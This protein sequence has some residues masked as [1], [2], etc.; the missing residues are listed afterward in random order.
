MAKWR[1]QAR[2]LNG[3]ELLFVLPINN[4]RLETAAQKI[5]VTMSKHGRPVIIKT[6]H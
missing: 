4:R 2:S 1:R 3:G 5:K 6:I